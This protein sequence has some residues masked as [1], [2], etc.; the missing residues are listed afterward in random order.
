MQLGSD[1]CIGSQLGS[2]QL[3]HVCKQSDATEQ[4]TSSKENK[5]RRGRE[6]GRPKLK[7]AL[8]NA[9]K[10]NDGERKTKK[11][12]MKLKKK[13]TDKENLKKAQK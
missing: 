3:P 10:K 1:F 9:E 8:T 12:R 6:M 13:R 4:L 5:G 2:H 7:N 11:T